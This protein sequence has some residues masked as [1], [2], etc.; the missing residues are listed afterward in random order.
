MYVYKV[1]SR[2]SVITLLVIK[3]VGQITMFN[4]VMFTWSNVN[5]IFGKKQYIIVSLSISLS[6]FPSLSLSDVV[7]V[8]QQ[9]VYVDGVS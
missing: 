9:M 4:D 2:V 5:A 1:I 6:L 3:F 8:S 7:L